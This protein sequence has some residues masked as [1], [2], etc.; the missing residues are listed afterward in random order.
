MHHVAF[1]CS[2]MAANALEALKLYE[3][4]DRAALF[5]GSR[6]LKANS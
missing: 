4:E 3:S 1:M 5:E 6:S 2:F